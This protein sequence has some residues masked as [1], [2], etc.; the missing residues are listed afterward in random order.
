MKRSI[1]S[2]ILGVFFGT[3]FVLGILPNVQAQ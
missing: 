2:I 1:K 3:L